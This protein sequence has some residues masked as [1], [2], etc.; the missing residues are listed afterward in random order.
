M[1]EME[2]NPSERELYLFLYALKYKQT[3]LTLIGYSVLIMLSYV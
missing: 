2:A 1:T 3:K